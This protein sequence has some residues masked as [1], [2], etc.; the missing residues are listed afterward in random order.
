MCHWFYRL[1]ASQLKQRVFS[2]LLTNLFLHK[3]VNGRSFKIWECTYHSPHKCSNSKHHDGGHEEQRPRLQ[4]QILHCDAVDLGFYNSDE[5][6][7]RRLCQLQVWVQR[8][9]CLSLVYIHWNTKTC[10]RI[11]AVNKCLNVGLLRRVPLSVELIVDSRR[12]FSISK[13]TVT[14]AVLD[15][16]L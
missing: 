4:K 14:A 5:A 13:D 11:D 15:R 3:K 10:L 6:Y 1:P 2:D 9:V 7:T 12:W 8:I 16:V